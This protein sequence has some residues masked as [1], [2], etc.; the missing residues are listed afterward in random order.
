MQW[1]WFSMT[2]NGRC[3]HASSRCIKSSRRRA[4]A[5]TPPSPSSHRAFQSR[6]SPLPS[7][8][9]RTPGVS[10]RRPASVSYQYSPQP[11][12]LASTSRPNSMVL[13]S[14]DSSTASSP[15]KRDSGVF[16]SLSRPRPSKASLGSD[17][18]SCP[19]GG[20]GQAPATTD[21]DHLGPEQDAMPTTY[22]LVSELSVHSQTLLYCCLTAV[23]LVWRALFAPC[24]AA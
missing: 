8:R 4:A 23:V 13:L 10:M 18:G 2:G 24:R 9:R 3:C 16:R 6:C 12:I 17:S 15:G 22:R 14:R 7:R 1:P 21:C 5:A 20:A 19:T 11:L